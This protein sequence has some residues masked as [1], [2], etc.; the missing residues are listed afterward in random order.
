MGW[1]GEIG[2]CGLLLDV[3]IFCGLVIG[4]EI[5]VWVFRF[6]LELK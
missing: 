5:V 1:G 2:E 6:G 4:S 3:R